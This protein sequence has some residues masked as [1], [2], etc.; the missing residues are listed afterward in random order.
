METFLL[1]LV[2][3]CACWFIAKLFGRRKEDG[4]DR[5]SSYNR[6]TRA[7][8][9][10]STPQQ[11][12]KTKKSNSFLRFFEYQPHVSFDNEAIVWCANFLS[13]EEKQLRSILKELPYQ[14]KF[15]SIRKRS[16]GR[17]VISAPKQQLLAVQQT[18][19]R[20]ILL[21]VPVHPAATGF[22]QNISIV[23]NAQPH[24]GKNQML[25]TDIRDFFGSIK[26][27]T[28]VK[29]FK[30]IG[31]PTN[32]SKVLAELCCYARCLPQGAPTSPALSN[33]IAYEMDKKLQALSD[34]FNLI[35]TR[36][37]DDLTFSGDVISPDILP[38]IAEILQESRF[39]LKATKTRFIPENKRKIITGVS[40]SSGYK[41]T[42]PKAKKRE[43]RKNIH[44]ILTKGLAEHQR[45]IG[46]TDSFY[47]KRT[48]GYLCYWLSVEPDNKY[49]QKS[50]S[51]LRQ[52]MC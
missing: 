47:L 40:I 21:P 24:L 5:G 34:E 2:I 52:L 38:R 4:Y 48:I 41:L 45:Y 10:Y 49:V 11:E 8:N 44:Y 25:K 30:T 36:Y 17:R 37:A 26:R 42:I 32:V 35:Y 33:I 31:Y 29:T 16:G 28:V 9:R 6:N 27:R 12:P 22:R 1:I 13:I 50:L 7:H 51:A 19:Y 46:S 20:R 15:F 23:H 3:V 39:V 18:I 14:Y 43:L